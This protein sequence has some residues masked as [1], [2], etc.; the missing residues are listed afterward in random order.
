M[1]TSILPPPFP[2]KRGSKPSRKIE[3][4]KARKSVQ[5]SNKRALFKEYGVPV[6]FGF[7]VGATAVYLVL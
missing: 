5:I 3:S 2:E 7:I 1:D 4:I 6:I